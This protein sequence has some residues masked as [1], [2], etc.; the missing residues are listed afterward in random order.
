M[1][2]PDLDTAA[3]VASLPKVLSSLVSLSPGLPLPSKQL[4]RP[5]FK[6]WGRGLRLASG[7]GQL[8]LLQQLLGR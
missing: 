1:L 3:L 2:T 4:H 6:L 8:L 7:S 5:K